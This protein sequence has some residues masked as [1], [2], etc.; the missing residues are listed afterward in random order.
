MPM[1][2]LCMN[3]DAHL[4]NQFP[5]LDGLPVDASSQARVAAWPMA[6]NAPAVCRILPGRRD[7]SLI[8]EIPP[9][10]VPEGKKSPRSCI[11]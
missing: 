8:H 4:W 7:H 11:P 9:R 6:G 2:D 10:N 5:G 1:F 3:G